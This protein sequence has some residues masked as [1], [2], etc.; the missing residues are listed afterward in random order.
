MRPSCDDLREELKLLDQLIAR[1]KEIVQLN[2]FAR[3][4]EHHRQSV[5][6]LL[7]TQRDIESMLAN[8]SDAHAENPPDFSSKGSHT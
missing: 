7:A 4:V 6:E 1:G 8:H 2:Q 3:D 5:N